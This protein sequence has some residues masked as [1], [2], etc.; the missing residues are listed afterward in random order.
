MIKQDIY[1]NDGKAEGQIQLADDI[2][3]VKPNINLL[4]QAVFVQLSNARFSTA[5][6]KTRAEV[7]GGG[8]KPW[9]QK[10]T[11]N[12]RAGSSR[13]PI[14]TGGGI[15]FGPRNDRNWSK[16]L[17]KKMRRKALFMA[18]SSKI[19]D[20]NLIVLDKINF[21]T[22]KTKNAENFLKKLPIEEGSILIIIPKSDMNVEL[23]FRNLPYVKTLLASSLNVYD[24]LKYDWLV[25]S[26]EAIKA[27]DMV[28]LKKETDENKEVKDEN[29][30]D[31]KEVKSDKT[32]ISKDKLKAKK[33]EK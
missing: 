21:S 25:V 31:K 7:R 23:S 12:A 8:R 18:L 20:K 13:S 30:T 5:H 22:V 17:S 16:S 24:I 9:K 27:I 26:K 1:K 32:K 33:A 15:T 29:K 28:Y 4:Q 2:F 11:G 3:A 19:L 10:G 6:T 14:W